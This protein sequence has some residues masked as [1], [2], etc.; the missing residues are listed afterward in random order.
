MPNVWGGFLDDASRLVLWARFAKRPAAG[1]L[2]LHAHAR[3]GSIYYRKSIP[4]FDSASRLEKM[5]KKGGLEDAGKTLA[6]LEK[7]MERLT[8][9]LLDC[10][11]KETEGGSP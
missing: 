1:A 11:R 7:E 8:S 10:I 5:G 2:R 3:K 4:A 9:V 6:V